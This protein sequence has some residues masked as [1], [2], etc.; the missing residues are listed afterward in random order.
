MSKKAIV[1]VDIQNDY[2]PGG[3]YPLVG[4]EEAADNAARVIAH[5]RE[6]GDLVIHVRHDALSPDAAFFVQ[7]SHGVQIHPKARNLPGET[8]IIKHQLNP[9]RD[10]PLKSSL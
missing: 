2:F 4:A 7:D 6:H 10:T 5:A 8:L 1:V 3:K 9:F